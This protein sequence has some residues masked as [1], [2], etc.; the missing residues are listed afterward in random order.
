M[1]SVVF[2]IKPVFRSVVNV[3]EQGE[4]LL[5]STSPLKE[6]ANQRKAYVWMPDKHERSPDLCRNGPLYSQI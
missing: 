2:L 6:A 5:S 4:V 1:A 3:R